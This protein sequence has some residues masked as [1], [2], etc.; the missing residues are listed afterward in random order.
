[1]SIGA[2]NFFNLKLIRRQVFSRNLSKVF[3]KNILLCLAFCRRKWRNLIKNSLSSKKKHYFYT[4][5]IGL[6]NFFASPPFSIIL[7]LPLTFGSLM[8]ILNKQKNSGIKKQLLTIFF[9][10]FGYFVSIFWWFVIPL[11]TDFGSL[12]WLTPFAILGLPFLMS[13][14]F[15]PFFC[16]GFLWLKGRKGGD[17]FNYDLS[18]FVV[19]L[20]CWFCGEYVRGHLIFGGFPWMLFGHFVKYSFAFQIVRLIGID[21]YSI[22]FLALVLSVY[23]FFFGEKNEKNQLLC[24]LIAGFWLVNCLIGGA[25][26]LFS[27]SENFSQTI[28]GSQPNIPAKMDASSDAVEIL[29]KNIEL[30]SW[31]ARSN[32]DMIKILPENAI[33]FYMESGSNASKALGRVVGNDKS[34]LLAGGIYSE[35]LAIYNVIYSVNN[36]GHIVSL[37]KKQK[38]VPFG[39]YIPVRQFMPF[40]TRTLTNGMVDFSIDGENDYFIFYRDLPIIYP[41]I[42]YESIF[43]DY[44][45]TNI[46]KNRRL[47]K[48]RFATISKEEND[49]GF[50]EKTKSLKERGELIVNVVNDAWMK[51]SVAGYQHFLMTRYLAV[52]TGLPVIRVSNNGISAFIDSCGRA[53]RQTK[54]NTEDVLFIAPKRV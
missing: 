34:L 5:L 20:I 33:S 53:V 10:L 3:I 37:Y 7:V 1:M 43:P 8:F 41:I 51:W 13:L 32:R 26:L 30:I 18:L 12:F 39:E 9:F 44:V 2:S 19:F 25:V 28:I 15:V 17:G 49:K 35:G 29:N 46:S 14:F 52:A 42:C 40:L 45:K 6:F 16:I 22:L 23:F 47:L 50:G 24:L 48:E 31:T 38:L 4:F 36:D 11:T 54:L 27:K 21:L